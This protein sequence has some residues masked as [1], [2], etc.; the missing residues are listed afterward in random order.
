MRLHVTGR[1]IVLI[2]GLSL[3]EAGSPLNEVYKDLEV[4]KS[5]WGVP[6]E[7][8]LEKRIWACS[9]NQKILRKSLTKSPNG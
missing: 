1:T 4:T 7:M 3:E 2:V 8:C 5:S 6:F 9:C